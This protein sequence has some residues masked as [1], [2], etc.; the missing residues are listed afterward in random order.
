MLLV[1]ILRL[2]YV[3]VFY[4]YWTV[5]PPIMHIHMDGSLVLYNLGWECRA[6]VIDHPL[7]LDAVNHEVTLFNQ[8]TISDKAILRRGIHVLF[9][10]ET[11][12]CIS[13]THVKCEPLS[14]PS[15]LSVL[16]AGLFF[17]DAMHAIQ[18]VPNAEVLSMLSVALIAY[19]LFHFAFCF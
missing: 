13:I 16:S 3:T 18:M 9:A 19:K 10:N 1:F 2:F 11:H 15:W 8:Y 6:S 17:L 12:P 5:A 4:A 14:M 7:E